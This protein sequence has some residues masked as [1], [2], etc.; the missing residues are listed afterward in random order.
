MAAKW[1]TFAWLYNGDSSPLLL[2]DAFTQASADMVDIHASILFQTLLSEKNYLRIE[3]GNLVGIASSVDISTKENMQDLIK[4]GKDLLMKPLSRVNL[5]TGTYE[6][7]KR[8]GTN[9]KALIRFAK[10]LSDE[11]RLRQSI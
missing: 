11:R 1:G 10:L 9:A 4:I 7:V 6:E 5:E 8:E 3:L 2:L